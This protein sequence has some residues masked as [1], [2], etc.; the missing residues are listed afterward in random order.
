[1]NGTHPFAY[2]SL[3]SGRCIAARG[4]DRKQEAARKRGAGGLVGYGVARPS[5]G[6]WADDLWQRPQVANYQEV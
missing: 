4:P 3:A 2:P 1:M 6:R 5:G